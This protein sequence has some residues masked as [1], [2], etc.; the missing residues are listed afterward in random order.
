MICLNVSKIVE[1]LR[2]FLCRAG[3]VDDPQDCQAQLPRGDLNL[4]GALETADLLPLFSFF[5]GNLS[6]HALRCP[7][8]PEG[9]PPVR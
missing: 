6:S 8:R 2:I 4:S 3:M 1:L 9:T 5:Q 7:V